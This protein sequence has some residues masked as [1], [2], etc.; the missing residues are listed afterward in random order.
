MGRQCLPMEQR[1]SYRALDIRKRFRCFIWTLW[2]AASCLSKPLPF[3]SLTLI[4]FCSEALG[5]NDG[6]IDHR[7]LEDRNFGLV[8]SIA[9]IDGILLY[10]INSF[11]PIEASALFTH[12]PVRINVYLVC[13]NSI[14]KANNFS[15]KHLS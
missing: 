8:L 11:F 2:Y 14:W 12:D 3:R 7:F 6:L 4:F 10:G 9:F 5:R 15:H 13:I 1:K